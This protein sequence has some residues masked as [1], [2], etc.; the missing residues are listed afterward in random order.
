MEG[1]IGD[2]KEKH[3]PFIDEEAGKNMSICII[4][5]YESEVLTNSE[6]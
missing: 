3:S 4:A 2:E 6:L 5:H 1:V